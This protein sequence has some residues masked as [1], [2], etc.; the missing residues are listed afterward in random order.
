MSKLPTH[1]SAA[2][3]V[4]RTLPQTEYDFPHYCADVLRIP[5]TTVLEAVASA[6]DP[7]LAAILIDRQTRTDALRSRWIRRRGSVPG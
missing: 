2:W 4:L 3:F 6:S 7:V 1:P 5:Q